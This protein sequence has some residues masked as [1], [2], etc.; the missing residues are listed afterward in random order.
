MYLD[1]RTNIIILLF[2][3]FYFR[4]NIVHIVIKKHLF[5]LFIMYFDLGTVKS[6]FL[7]FF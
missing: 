3:Y 4:T 1:F 5:F 6:V 7:E 2:F